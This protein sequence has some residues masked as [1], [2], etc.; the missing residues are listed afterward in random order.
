M[1]NPNVYITP[2][3]IAKF[4]TIQLEQV[5]DNKVKVSGIKGDNQLHSTKYQWHTKMALNP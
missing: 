2:D 4:S 1:G 5:A 3:V